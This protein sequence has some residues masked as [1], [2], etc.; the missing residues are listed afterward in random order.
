MFTSPAPF[1][2]P[3]LSACARLP[4]DTPSKTLRLELNEADNARALA[5]D[6]ADAESTEPERTPRTIRENAH[7]I[8]SRSL[9]TFLHRHM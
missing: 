4:E 3:N 6:E 8:D 7:D 9:A 2:P 1:L 5:P